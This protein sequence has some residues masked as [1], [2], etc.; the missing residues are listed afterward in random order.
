MA[1]GGQRSFPRKITGVTT[2]FGFANAYQKIAFESALIDD[3][4]DRLELYEVDTMK[5]VST[6]LW[7]T[8]GSSV[9]D[10]QYVYSQSIQLLEARRVQL[11]S[12]IDEAVE[13]EDEATMDQQQKQQVLKDQI[14]RMI[15]P[16][17]FA[18]E[19]RAR[20]VAQ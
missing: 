11:G 5:A 18:L 4:T 6:R 15:Y 8:D 10:L 7:L 1:T 16:L 2:A 9:E 14:S 3:M 19:A 17:C 12:A 13:A 20:Y